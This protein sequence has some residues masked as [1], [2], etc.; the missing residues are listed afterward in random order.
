M[1]RTSAMRIAGRGSWW[2]GLLLLAS[3]ADPLS[4]SRGFAPDYDFAR[5]H[6][7]DHAAHAEPGAATA[8]REQWDRAVENALETVLARKGYR[9]K[10]DLPDFLVTWT[11]SEWRVDRRTRTGGGWGAVGP[12]FPGLHATPPPKSADE[13]ALPPSVDPYSRWC[14]KARLDLTVIDARTRRV[15]WWASIEDE[16][17]FGYRAEAQRVR[18]QKAVER[19]LA[20]FPPLP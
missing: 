16:G 1:K 10:A 8:G 20:D 12:A 5:L 18:I 15:V 11:F 14:E 6:T 17:N 19:A 3:C 4:L 7:W 9:R 13:R 2:C